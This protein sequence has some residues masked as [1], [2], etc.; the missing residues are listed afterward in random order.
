VKG[1]S[2]TILRLIP[3]D[4]IVKLECDM[5]GRGWHPLAGYQDVMLLNRW[6]STLKPVMSGRKQDAAI[7]LHNYSL[8]FKI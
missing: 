2:P 8:C 6:A 1:N 5:V 3:T 7:A 4:K